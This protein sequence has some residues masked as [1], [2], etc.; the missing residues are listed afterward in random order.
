MQD[1]LFSEQ[2][3][4]SFLLVGGEKRENMFPWTQGR[5]RRTKA[6]WSACD[7]FLPIRP[8]SRIARNEQRWR[9]MEEDRDDHSQESV[10]RR[11]L[12]DATFPPDVSASRSA[13]GTQSCQGNSAA[14]SHH[15]VLE[16]GPRAEAFQGNLLRSS[17]LPFEGGS[18][19]STHRGVEE[20]P[21]SSAP[22]LVLDVPAFADNFYQDLLDWS[23]ENM[24]VVGT[25]IGV[26][27]RAMATGQSVVFSD[28]PRVGALR[29]SRDASL[30][31][32]ADT[33]GSIR[34]Y[35][36]HN[37]VLVRKTK[38]L[39]ANYRTASLDFNEHVLTAAAQRSAGPDSDAF[40]HHYDMR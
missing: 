12:R 36:G 31:A 14:P 21:L 1:T 38:L 34:L 16:F 23:A 22:S 17:S 26:Y 29:F 18:A 10:Y 15:R 7:R 8:T 6:D 27:G 5:N 35:D 37:G 25:R 39:F 20:R 4:S 33:R 30:L 32:T 28:G 3:K 11:S 13:V 40:I 2:R 19:G 9:L 24:L